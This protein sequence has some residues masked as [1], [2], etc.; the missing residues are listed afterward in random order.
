[1]TKKIKKL[2]LGFRKG[3]IT[4]RIKSNGDFELELI[5]DKVDFVRD[6]ESF[7]VIAGE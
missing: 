7:W 5:K 3:P 4:E 2:N 6:D 1:M